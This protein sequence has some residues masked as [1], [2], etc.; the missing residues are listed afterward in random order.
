MSK[1]SFQTIL[2]GYWV[3]RAHHAGFPWAWQFSYVALF[4]STT[5]R[6]PLLGNNEIGKVGKYVYFSC[7]FWF[8]VLFPGAFVFPDLSLYV[9]LK[10]GGFLMLL[11]ISKSLSG[12]ENWIKYLINQ[13]ECYSIT[14][15]G[16]CNEMLHWARNRDCIVRVCEIFSKSMTMVV[17][18]STQQ[19]LKQMQRTS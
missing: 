5:L 4:L 15:N 11:E 17:K 3:C 12:Q 13:K 2:C 16:T 19:Y 1:F 6:N 7:Q 14:H 10:A 18:D 9:R 8:W